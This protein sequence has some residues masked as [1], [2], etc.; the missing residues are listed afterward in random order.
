LPYPF[1]V[2]A[3]DGDFQQ[4]SELRRSGVVMRP[5][6]ITA[7]KD[8]GVHLL[9]VDDDPNVCRALWRVFRPHGFQMHAAHNAD[10]ALRIFQELSVDILITDMR[11]PGRSG[12]ELLAQISE[13]HAHTHRILL[14]GYADL[15]ETTQAV[16]HGLVDDFLTKPWEPQQIEECVLR[17]R[18]VREAL[19]AR[20]AAS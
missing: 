3:D 18:H 4:N 15:R 12:A 5:E 6:E 14:T 7:P 9:F 2:D 13:S 20:K 10:E 16:R 11:M 1:S 19:E 17:T 8:L